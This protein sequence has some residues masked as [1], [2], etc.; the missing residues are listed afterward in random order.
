[1]EA[2]P[3]HHLDALASDLRAHVQR[4][5]P[6]ADDP[7]AVE[8]QALAANDSQYLLARLRLAE[9]RHQAESLDLCWMAPGRRSSPRDALQ[10]I[11]AICGH[12]ASLYDAMLTVVATHPEVSRDV[13]AR[14][15]QQFRSEL[16]SQGPEDVRSLLTAAWVGGR[17]G[18]DA[19]LRTRR[20]AD[21]KA[22][23]LPWMAA[24]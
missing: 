24:D 21:R 4:H 6:D 7:A 14:A 3:P 17:E 16:S 22:A 13:L 8:A 23:S 5:Y 11:K 20:Q 2:S 12:R 10:R 1:M 9:A 19:V 15:V 18:F